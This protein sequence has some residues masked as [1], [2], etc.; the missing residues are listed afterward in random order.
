M[1]KAFKEFNGNTDKHLN[2]LKDD[3][4][5]FL[6]R[7]QENTSIWLDEMTEKIQDLKTNFSKRKDKPIKSQ[8]KIK[9]EF[10]IQLSK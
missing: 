8:R 2:E 7:V 1:I 6:R 4:N 5:E 3:R 10:K 9:M